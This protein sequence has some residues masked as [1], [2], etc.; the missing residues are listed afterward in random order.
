MCK[1]SPSGDD[2]A[3]QANSE[4]Q[5]HPDE[6]DD[7]SFVGYVFPTHIERLGNASR[8]ELY[9]CRSCNSF[10]RF[11]RY[12]KAL[13]ITTTRR[14][15]CGEY[16][17]L[18]YRILRSL[19]YKKLRWV[20]DWADH[21]WVDIRLGDSIGT[22][23]N[24]TYGRWVHCDPC[25]A[26]IDEPLLYEGWGKNQTYIVAF[27][28]PFNKNAVEVGDLSDRDHHVFRFPLIE[29]VTAA[30][31]TDNDDVV[32]DRRGIGDEFIAETIREVSRNLTTMLN[33]TSALPAES[34]NS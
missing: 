30:Y 9:R 17:M 34:R 12:N 22:S 7:V 10:T 13:W 25:E 29:D 20:V 2:S 28:D 27:Y 3:D 5:I 31:T 26:S 18:M 15:R 32:I 24:S 14:G 6:E 11:P 21:V 19:G 23:N 8:T 4:N 16:S 1:D 33:Q